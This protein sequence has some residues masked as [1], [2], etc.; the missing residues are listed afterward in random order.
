MRLKDWVNL[1]IDV[2]TAVGVLPGFSPA[3]QRF[4]VQACQA[5]TGGAGSPAHIAEKA[6][7]VFPLEVVQVQVCF[8]FQGE[9]DGPLLLIEGGL[10]HLQF[11]IGPG[12]QGAVG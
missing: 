12:G 1:Q 11:Q 2:L 3:G 10:G 4:L 6:E 9:V 8:G 5:Q 7:H